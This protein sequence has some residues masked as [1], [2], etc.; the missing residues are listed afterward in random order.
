M[1]RR[2]NKSMPKVE[3]AFLYSDAG[4]FPV[5]GREWSEW[6]TSHT[7]FYFQHP[8]GTFTARKELRSGGWYW[9]AFRKHQSKL[10]KLYMGKSEEITSARLVEIARLLDERIRAETVSV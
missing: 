3:S 4:S 6:I 1:P 2:E 10:Y 5:G 7:A 9:Y 8:A